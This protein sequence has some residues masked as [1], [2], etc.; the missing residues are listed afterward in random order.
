MSSKHKHRE[1]NPADYGFETDAAVVATGVRIAPSLQAARK[2]KEKE[3]EQAGEEA[4]E[5]T[6]Q[7]ESSSMR[8]DKGGKGGGAEKEQET[9]HGK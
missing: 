3:K 5:G 6:H 8:K 4:G 7:A 9:E 2:E 1:S